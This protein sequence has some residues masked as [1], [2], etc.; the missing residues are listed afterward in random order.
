LGQAGGAESA[1]AAGEGESSRPSD[2]AGARSFSA[3]AQSNARMKEG[4][5]ALGGRGRSFVLDVAWLNRRFV[6]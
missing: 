4:L 1:G 2:Q 5:S 3:A 6:W